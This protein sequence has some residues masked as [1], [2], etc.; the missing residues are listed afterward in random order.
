MRKMRLQIHIFPK[1]CEGT[2]SGYEY[3]Y[4]EIYKHTQS[5]YRNDVKMCAYL[6]GNAI[7]KEYARK[8]ME[9]LFKEDYYMTVLG[10]RPLMYYF[11]TSNN[12][13]AWTIQR[14]HFELFLNVK[15]FLFVVA[16][17]RNIWPNKC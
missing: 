17:I 1:I 16:K 14:C 13:I 7:N 9:T 15:H 4:W 12:L 8:D 11:G 10:G 5:K 6:D 2:I 3:A